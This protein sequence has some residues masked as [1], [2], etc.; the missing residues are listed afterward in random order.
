MTPSRQASEDLEQVYF[1]P[2]C[3]RVRA[4]LPIDEKDVHDAKVRF[5]RPV[6]LRSY[7]LPIE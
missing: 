3:M 4:V 6:V 5:K 2:A 1:C 7:S